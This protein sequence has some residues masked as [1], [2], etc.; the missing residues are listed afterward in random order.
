MPHGITE[1]VMNYRGGLTV[2]VGANSSVM[3]T[4]LPKRAGVSEFS[5]LNRYESLEA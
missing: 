3:N 2:E 4:T 1:H 5:S